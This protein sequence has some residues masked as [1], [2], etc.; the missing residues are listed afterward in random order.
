MI[1]NRK[2]TELVD[3]E[4]LKFC[5]KLQEKVELEA[6]VRDL[7]KELKGPSTILIHI[8]LVDG[9]VIKTSDGREIHLD[10]YMGNKFVRIHR[11]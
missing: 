6:R 10:F 2:I 1:D 3:S 7:K 4:L 5:D 11:S 9:Q 8:H